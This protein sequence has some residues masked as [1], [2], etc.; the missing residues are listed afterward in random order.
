MR[1]K[2]FSKKQ[3][4]IERL[5]K[6]FL[7]HRDDMAYWYRQGDY[8][9]YLISAKRASVIRQQMLALKGR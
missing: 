7:E 2:L 3:K 1:V 8:E 5:R 9:N 6:Q 4:R